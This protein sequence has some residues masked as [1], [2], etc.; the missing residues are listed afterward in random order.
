MDIEEI[1]T[2]QAMAKAKD[3]EDATPVA[4]KARVDNQGADKPLSVNKDACQRMLVNSTYA[5]LEDLL[6]TKVNFGA[7]KVVV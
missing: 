6:V 5:G 4:K 7:I 2:K 3:N 1:E